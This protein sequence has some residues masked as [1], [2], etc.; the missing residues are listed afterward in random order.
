[1]NVDILIFAI[2]AVVIAYRLYNTLGAVDDD[3]NVSTESNLKNSSNVVNLTDDQYE[4]V[5]NV[6][7]EEE[8]RLVD[9]LDE[10]DKDALQ[11]IKSIDKKF[12][13][14]QFLENSEKAFEMII[15]AFTSGDKEV[16]TKL[17]DDK[18]SKKFLSEFNNLKKLKRKIDVNIVAIVANV[19][20]QIEF[21]AKIARISI[22]LTSEQI[23]TTL[24]DEGN[25]LSGSDKKIEEIDDMWVFQRDFTVE[26]PA[27][28]LVE[29]K[30]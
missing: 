21:D 2:I 22:K 30:S 16:L 4:E 27:W 24:D 19:V 8:Q 29:M 17:A 11:N 20:N 28:L 14:K 26:N 10:G 3:S 1:M 18:V 6:V 25:S 5:V 13:L 12:K 15:A 7:D 23:T 9:N